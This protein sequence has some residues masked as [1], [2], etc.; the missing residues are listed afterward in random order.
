MAEVEF[1]A[2]PEAAR[3]QKIWNEAVEKISPPPTA[4][5]APILGINVRLNVMKALQA[6][7]E[8][9]NVAVKAVLA[10]HTTFDPIT[11]I[12]IGVEAWGAVQT[13]IASLVQTMSPINYITYVML[14]QSPDGIDEVTLKQSVEQ[15]LRAPELSKF[16]WH[17]G[18]TES[19]AKRAL[20]ATQQPNWIKTTMNKLQT[21]N[22][23]ELSGNLWKFVP[24][25]FTLRG[26]G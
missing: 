20:E 25:N 18:M 23:A 12:G 9:A 13:L 17:L 11:W 24:R 4:A 22:M 15:F 7:W 1:T 5:K 21:D 2:S 26:E 10:G 14:S 3:I 19:I 6:T 16:A 8:T